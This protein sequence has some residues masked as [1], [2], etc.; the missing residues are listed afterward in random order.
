MRGDSV[1]AGAWKWEGAEGIQVKNLLIDD[2]NG[3]FVIP[4]NS[5]GGCPVRKRV[6]DH[7]V[8]KGIPGCPVG[9]KSESSIEE[10][11]R[12]STLATINFVGKEGVILRSRFAKKIYIRPRKF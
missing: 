5:W 11:G 1:R 4:R 2:G 10:Q 6:S 9:K 12:R 8:G 7:L 3:T